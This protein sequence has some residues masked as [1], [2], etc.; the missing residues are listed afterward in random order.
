MTAD[1]LYQTRLENRFPKETIAALREELEK[2][3]IFRDNDIQKAL[4]DA[5]ANIS[6]L[7]ETVNSLRHAME[8]RKIQYE[9]E[10]ANHSPY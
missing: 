8:K 7:K 1:E 4:A 9:D 3:R 6:E 10:V 2:E 5:H